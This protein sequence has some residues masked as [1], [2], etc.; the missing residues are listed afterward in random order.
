LAAIS[1]LERAARQARPVV[2]GWRD[3][4]RSAVAY[5]P[6]AWDAA[7]A[8]AGRLHPVQALRPLQAVLDAHPDAVFVC[9]GGEIGQWA[10][11]CLA[12]PHRVINRVAGLGGAALPFAVAAR[13]AVPD[14]PVVAVM[15]DGTFGFH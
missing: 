6:A 4:V 7:T 9:D 1:A 11:A 13:A 2:S 8:E 15:G 3:E 12:A 14:A 5:R 10:Q